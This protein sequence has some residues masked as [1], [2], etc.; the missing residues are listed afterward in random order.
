MKKMNNEPT[1][2]APNKEN[3]KRAWVQPL[4]IVK[5]EDKNSPTRHSTIKPFTEKNLKHKW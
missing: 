4:Y 5:D 3:K 1:Q 2:S